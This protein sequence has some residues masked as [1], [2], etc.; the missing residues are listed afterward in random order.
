V[1]QH[2]LIRT[3]NDVREKLADWQQEY[4]CERP[5]SSPDYRTQQELK[6]ACDEI[7]A[8]ALISPHNQNSNSTEKTSVM[9]G[10]ETGSQVMWR[11]LS[12]SNTTNPE[13]SMDKRYTS[14][15][16]RITSSGYHKRFRTF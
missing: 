9:T 1:P 13:G 7:R 11:P 8:M 5:H 10:L 4:N 2:E 12:A 3:L 14:E 16:S 15:H 6:R